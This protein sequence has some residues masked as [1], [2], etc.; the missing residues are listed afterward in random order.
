MNTLQLIMLINAVG[1]LLC[2]IATAIALCLSE[3]L[4]FPK[5]I[6]AFRAENLK[7]VAEEEAG[8]SA[9]GGGFSD[10]CG[11]RALPPHANSGGKLA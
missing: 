6:F 7:P 10:A 2:L 5:R 1:I 9:A 3:I 11:A 4:T 8:A